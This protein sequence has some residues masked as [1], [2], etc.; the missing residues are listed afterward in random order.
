MNKTEIASTIRSL[1]LLAAGGLGINGLEK[2]ST[3]QIGAVILAFLVMRWWSMR[4]HKAL[5]ETGDTNFL[6]IKDAKP[7]ASSA[8]APADPGERLSG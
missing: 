6:G 2:S 1:I 5:K 3:L 4:D 8:D 7:S